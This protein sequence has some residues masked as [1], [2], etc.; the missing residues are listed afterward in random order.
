MQIF[1]F[2][3]LKVVYLGLNYFLEKAYEIFFIDFSDISIIVM[4]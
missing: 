2:V 1:Q 3:F 4:G